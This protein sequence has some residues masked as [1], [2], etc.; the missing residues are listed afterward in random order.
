LLVLRTLAGHI[1]SVVEGV[2]LYKALRDRAEH[3]STIYEVA[4]A[5][6][7][8]L[9]PDELL[10]EVVNLVEKKFGFQYVHIFSVHTGRGKIFYET[11]CG[12]STC[13]FFREEGFAYDL[14]DPEGI[15][16]WVARG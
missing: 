11:G 4:R 12:S 16:P 1:A 6:T 15:I 7:S 3:L 9:D 8:I 13:E 10:S 2:G 5:V 14:D